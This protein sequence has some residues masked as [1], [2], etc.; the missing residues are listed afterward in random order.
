[1]DR[2]GDKGEH[3]GNPSVAKCDG[4]RGNAAVCCEKEDTQKV[5][6]KVVNAPQEQS[7]VDVD[8]KAKEG[9]ETASTVERRR[10][11]GSEGS[12]A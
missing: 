6:V 5:V 8:G 3:E 2:L 4:G 11:R 10:E 12:L 7:S 9:N 1:M